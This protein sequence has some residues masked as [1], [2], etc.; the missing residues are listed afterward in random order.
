MIT[1]YKAWD[2]SEKKMKRVYSIK[3]NEQGEAIAIQDEFANNYEVSVTYDVKYYELLQS[4]GLFDKNGTEIFIGDLILTENGVEE[5]T[6]TTQNNCYGVYLQYEKMFN[7]PIDYYATRISL[8]HIK[9]EI[10][11]NKFEHPHLLGED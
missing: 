6:F 4:T 10:I 2:K 3:F 11:G 5:V 1:K 8:D 9:G 7:T